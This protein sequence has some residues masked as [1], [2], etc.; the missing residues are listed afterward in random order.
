[1]NKHINFMKQLHKQHASRLI[2]GM[3]VQMSRHLN[4]IALDSYLKAWDDLKS[5]DLESLQDNREFW[6]R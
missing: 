5:D 4:T 2:D 1:M 6:G 3:T